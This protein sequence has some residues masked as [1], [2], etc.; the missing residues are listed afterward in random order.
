VD[1]SALV[2]RHFVGPDLAGL[3]E[4]TTLEVDDAELLAKGLGPDGLV[5]GELGGPVAVGVVFGVVDLYGG[6]DPLLRCEGIEVRTGGRFG[7]GG[8]FRCFF[9]FGFGDELFFMLMDVL[10]FLLLPLLLL[11]LSGGRS[12][13]GSR[14]GIRSKLLSLSNLLRI[15]GLLCRISLRLIGRDSMVMLLGLGRLSYDLNSGCRADLFIFAGYESR[16]SSGSFF[17]GNKRRGLVAVKKKNCQIKFIA[18]KRGGN[19]RAYTPLFAAG[20]DSEGELRWKCARPRNMV[21]KT[22][23]AKSTALFDLGTAIFWRSDD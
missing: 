5:G 8:S 9:D 14:R 1:F 4:A 20:V 17:L 11:L 22:T 15:A 18:A 3:I 10:M 13:G 7:N 2:P 21:T 19:G 6:L 12:S 16:G 23:A